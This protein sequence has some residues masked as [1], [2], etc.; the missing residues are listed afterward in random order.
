MILK[1]YLGELCKGVNVY[2]VYISKFGTQARCLSF[3]SEADKSWLH[4]FRWLCLSFWF[5]FIILLFMMISFDLRTPSFL[6]PL[7]P[8]K[9][10]FVKGAS[11]NRMAWGRQSSGTTPR[12]AWFVWGR[13]N[14]DRKCNPSWI[15]SFN[16]NF[17]RVLIHSWGA[18]RSR[19]GYIFFRIRCG[20]K[21]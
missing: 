2:G 5:Y 16:F 19:A 11:C 14:I 8:R 18:H 3:V 4:L 1:S 7:W 12:A 10:L 17:T 20:P 21:H 15:F 13:R 9:T 6:P